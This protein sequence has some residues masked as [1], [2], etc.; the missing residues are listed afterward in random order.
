[1]ASY[2]T[3]ATARRD[4]AITKADVDAA[5][6]R[7]AALLGEAPSS[8]ARAAVA[9]CVVA[10]NL[11]AL[12]ESVH[13]NLPSD[14]IEDADVLSLG[15][16][17]ASFHR[18]DA[19]TPARSSAGHDALE[20]L[21]DAQEGE[22]AKHADAASLARTRLQGLLTGLPFADDAPTSEARGGPRRLR[23][24]RR[25]A[26][27]AA[28][29][30]AVRRRRRL[31]WQGPTRGTALSQRRGL[32]LSDASEAKKQLEEAEATKKTA[33]AAQRDAQ[34]VLDGDAGPDGA[35]HVLR[36]RCFSVKVSQYT[37]E[38]CAFGRAKQDHTRLGNFRNGGRQHEVVLR[39]RPALSRARRAGPRRV[40]QMW[41]GGAAGERR[42]AGGRCSY[43]AI[44]I[45]RRLVVKRSGFYDA[46]QLRGR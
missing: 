38:V 40:S 43:S 37:Y 3:E 8:I 33:E 26:S 45:R 19:R 22:E 14:T 41:F 17:A 1:M 11:E 29:R 12:L 2:E 10:D 21:N 25:D 31:S 16:A 6:Q 20:A 15:A 13:E 34:K 4:A 36:D 7:E 5:A 32:P 28:P 30:A 39:R 35:Y 46:F 18:R 23:E 24:N 27:E 42:R 9:L 44:F